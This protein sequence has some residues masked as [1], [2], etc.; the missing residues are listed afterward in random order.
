MINDCGK[1]CRK[2]VNKALSRNGNAEKNDIERTFPN[3]AGAG[4]SFPDSTRE[5]ELLP[6]LAVI[7]RLQALHS[8]IVGIICGG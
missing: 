4:C 7:T 5:R 8:H 2:E 1:D 6:R 3:G